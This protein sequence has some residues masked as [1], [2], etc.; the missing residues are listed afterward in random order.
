MPW[1]LALQAILIMLLM[2]FLYYAILLNKRLGNLRASRGELEKLIHTFADATNRADKSIHGFKSTADQSG[3]RLQDAIVRSQGLRDD[4][5]FLIEKAENMAD[6][7]DNGINAGRG[8]LFVEEESGKV[9][10]DSNSSGQK[11]RSNAVRINNRIDRRSADYN[12]EPK[13]PSAAELKQE[14]GLSG[15]K[16]HG[17][18]SSVPARSISKTEQELMKSIQSLG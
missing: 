10:S 7:L 8:R 14:Q 13:Q 9:L 4:L 12:P 6:R 2:A 1:D 11:E 18:T 17:V 5:V 3:K 15:A 16:G